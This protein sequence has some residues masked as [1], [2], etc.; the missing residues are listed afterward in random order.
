MAS[1]IAPSSEPGSRSSHSAPNDQD[2]TDERA[3]VERWVA[4]RRRRTIAV[5]L[6]RLIV[7]FGFFGVWEFGSGRWFDSFFYSSPSAIAQ[8]LWTWATDGTLWFHASLT[9]TTL[10]YGFVIGLA[11]ALVA[12]YLLGTVTYLGRVLEPFITAVYSIPKMALVP[13]FVL[14]FGIG[15]QLAVL[16]SALVTFFLMFYNTFFGVKDVD[17]SLVNAVLVMGGSRRDLGLRVRL[18]SAL[19]WVA[20]GLKVSI[21]MALIGVVVAEI[22]AGNRGLGYLVQNS[23]NRF[24]STGTFAALTALLVVGLT[25]DKLAS[26]ATRR[27]LSW[28]S[29]NEG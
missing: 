10:V 1:T 11:V 6:G 3:G 20:A 9:L 19:V 22:L 28:R 4:R 25:L 2:S 14:W 21:P 13:L 18:P 27:A 16:M 24:D 23:A 17:R 7:L 8:V 26:A 29:G 15:P 5:V 12:G